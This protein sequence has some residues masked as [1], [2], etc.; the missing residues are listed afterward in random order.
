MNRN[1]WYCRFRKKLLKFLQG[2]KTGISLCGPVK[3]GTS[4][5]CIRTNNG[6]W[7]Q[8]WSNFGLMWLTRTANKEH[9]LLCS[10]IP[11][12][13]WKCARVCTQYQPL[14]LH[15][16]FIQKF[17][18]RQRSCVEFSSYIKLNYTPTKT[19]PFHLL[20]IAALEKFFS[21]KVCKFFK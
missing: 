12:G 8:Y 3:I 7:I 21:A 11:E 1:Y 18:F 13:E 9:P 15:S 5:C 20:N 19:K 2:V 10:K 14:V 4:V 6:Q 17:G 16:I